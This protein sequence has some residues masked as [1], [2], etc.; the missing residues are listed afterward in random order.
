MMAVQLL[1]IFFCRSI[2]PHYLLQFTY[3][4]G[5]AFYMVFNYYHAH[6]DFLFVLIDLLISGEYEDD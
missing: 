2:L 5:G 4:L 1:S 3:S 6:T